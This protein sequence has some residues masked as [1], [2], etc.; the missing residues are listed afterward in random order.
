[1]QGTRTELGAG[2]ASSR[3][4]GSVVRAAGGGD[5]GKKK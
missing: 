1:V 3:V 5:D 4:E 2:E